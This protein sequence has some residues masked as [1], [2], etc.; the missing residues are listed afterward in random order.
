MRSSLSLRPI[1]L[2]EAEVCPTHSDLLS[3][4]SGREARWKPGGDAPCIY[5]T[6][7][8][9][10]QGVDCGRRRDESPSPS[11]RKDLH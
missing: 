6:C 5:M 9:V 11:S 10:T 2:V 3:F 4:L 8:G 7:V 1:A